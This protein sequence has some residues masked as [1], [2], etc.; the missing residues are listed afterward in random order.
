MKL[1]ALAGFSGFASIADGTIVD[2]DKASLVGG[3]LTF[4]PNGMQISIED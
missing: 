1:S 2:V 4:G 3:E